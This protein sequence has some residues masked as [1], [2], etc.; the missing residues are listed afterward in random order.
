MLEEKHKKDIREYGQKQAQLRRDVEEKHGK[1]VKALEKEHKKKVASLVGDLLKKSLEV[2]EKYTGK[3][4][5]EGS[6]KRA[7]RE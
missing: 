4:S 5:V 6:K 3:A 7:R 1:C 2:A